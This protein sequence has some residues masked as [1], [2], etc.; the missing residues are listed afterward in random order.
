M[1]RNTTWL[2]P[3]HVVPGTCDHCQK[4]NRC[5][6]IDLPMNDQFIEICLDCLRA[7]VALL[8]ENQETKAER[9]AWV[10]PGEEF[11]PTE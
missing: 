7:A 2:D 5:V 8:E 9:M 3:M 6:R 4:E 10:Q 11:Y 1:S